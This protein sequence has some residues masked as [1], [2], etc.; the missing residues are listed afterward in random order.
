MRG[1]LNYVMLL[2]GSSLPGLT[3]IVQVIAKVKQKR[4]TQLY[5]RQPLLR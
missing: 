2:N 3:P 1:N 4:L 5:L